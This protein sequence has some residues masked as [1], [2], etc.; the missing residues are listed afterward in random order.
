MKIAFFKLE[1]WAKTVV[2]N[3]AMFS[4]HECVFFDS[5]LN[6]DT[7]PTEK[8]FEVISIFVDS[9]ITPEV[10]QAL[11]DLKLITT[12]STGYDHIDIAAC[13]KNGVLVASVPAYG[14]NTVAEFTFALMLTL[15][16]KIFESV[17]HIKETGSFSGTELQG[18][19]IKGKTLGVVGTGRIGKHVIKI[20]KGFGMNVLASDAH[21]DDKMALEFGFQYMPLEKLL[22]ES[23]IITLHVPYFKET[24]HLINKNNIGKIKK[25]AYLVNTSR[26][27]VVETEAL[28]SALRDGILAGAGLDVLEEEGAT[29][30]EL[31]LL[32]SDHLKVHSMKTILENHVLMNM[33]NVIVTPHNAF[34]TKEAISRILD[35]SLENIQG[36]LSGQPVNIVNG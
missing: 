12:R 20:A 21:P 29:K 14:E 28:I 3:S 6:A 35:T 15:S 32:V 34:N 5:I 9:S 4:G 27:G 22:A 17:H 18:F 13:K 19:D 26:G 16:R 11:P 1:P 10:L 8:N 30:D 31:S 7:I 2:E 33:K 36:F 25:G 24:H 23:D